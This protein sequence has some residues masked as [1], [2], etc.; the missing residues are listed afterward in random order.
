MAAPADRPRVGLP[1]REGR[2]CAHRDAEDV[3]PAAVGAR[4]T[5][6]PRCRAPRQAAALPDRRRR[7]RAARPPDD[8][9]PPEDRCRP[10]R[11][12]RRRPRSSSSSPAARSSSSRRTAKRKRAGVWLMTPELAAAELDHLGPEALGL[13]AGRA[14]R[15]HAARV[16]PPAPATSATSTRSPASAARGRTRSCTRRSSRRTHCR[17]T[18]ATRRSS[19]SRR[20]WTTSSA[21]AS[22][23]ARPARRTSA[24]TA[25]TT[26]SGQPCHVCGTAIAQ[27]DFEEHTIF[28]CPV[29]QTGGRVLKDRRLS[30]LLR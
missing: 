25:S 27:V 8:L 3:R 20:R 4:R 16:A 11:P 22:R 10:A 30:R 18:S 12:A 28:Y 29:C 5:H 6:A 13:D 17:R 24:H 21:A 7:A 19:G 9:G 15:D 14:R 23:C 1:D 2:P 26:G